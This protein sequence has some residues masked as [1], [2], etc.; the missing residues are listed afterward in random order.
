MSNVYNPRIESVPSKSNDP[1][2]LSA[3]TELEISTSVS[4]PTPGGA[5]EGEADRDK[6]GEA[7][8]PPG[9]NVLL[10]WEVEAAAAAATT[11]SA[12]TTFGVAENDFGR[13]INVYDS[14]LSKLSATSR[15]S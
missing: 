1:S 14:T 10:S 13:S 15:F 12:R 8:V 11:E 2:V 4:P 7:R 9:V 3:K 5:K 6:V